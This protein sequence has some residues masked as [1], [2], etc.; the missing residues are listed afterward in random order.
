MRSRQI[1]GDP[2]HKFFE[3]RICTRSCG[4]LHP[5]EWPIDG[6]QASRGCYINSCAFCLILLISAGLSGRPR[7]FCLSSTWKEMIFRIISSRS[8]FSSSDSSQT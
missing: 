5:C 1:M 6:V 7:A 3:R 2:P 4:A 8:F